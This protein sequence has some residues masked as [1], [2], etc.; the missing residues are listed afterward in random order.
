MRFT[1]PRSCRSDAVLNWEWPGVYKKKPC[2]CVS[3]FQAS[4]YLYYLN[5]YSSILYLISL[6]TPRCPLTSF[7]H[8]IFIDLASAQF[9]TACPS[10]LHQPIR[11]SNLA[12]D[13][14]NCQLPSS[15]RSI[16][17]GASCCYSFPIH[18]HHHATQSHQR[19]QFYPGQRR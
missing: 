6:P 16:P 13:L 3:S 17:L 9:N 7:L 12:A 14:V 5:L 10:R 15:S 19:L 11:P 8:L 4:L 18:L 2:C 1:V